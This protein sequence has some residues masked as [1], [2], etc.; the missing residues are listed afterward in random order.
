LQRNKKRSGITNKAA[1]NPQT[2]VSV[3][4]ASISTQFDSIKIYQGKDMA[5]S[6]ALETDFRRHLPDLELPRFTSMQ[7]QHA[8]DYADA[9]KST[10]QPPWLH[11]LYV[12]WRKLFEEPYHGITNDGKDLFSLQEYRCADY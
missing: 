3:N 11:G 2:F 5:A 6:N 1:I 8:A 7:G 4:L 9:F 10:G 12:H